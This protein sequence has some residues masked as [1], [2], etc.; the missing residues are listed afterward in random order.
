MALNKS[1]VGDLGESKFMYECI[2]R[3]FTIAKPFGNNIGYDLIVDNGNRMFRVQ[4]K[5]STRAYHGTEVYGNT[6]ETIDHLIKYADVVVCVSMERKC[7]YL[8]PI[9]KLDSSKI[10]MGVVSKWDNYK[11]NWSVLEPTVNK[12]PYNVK[13]VDSSDE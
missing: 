13:V 12:V 6:A 3:G 4:V 11:N 5:T 2:K 7:V 1:Q 8:I 10:N 9:S